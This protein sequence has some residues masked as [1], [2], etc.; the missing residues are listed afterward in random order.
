MATRSI[1][2]GQN[3]TTSEARRPCSA[4]EVACAP[5][6]PASLL[7][8]WPVPN[9]RCAAGAWDRSAATTG[10][11]STVVMFESPCGVGVHAAR[12]GEPPAAMRPASARAPRNSLD[13]RMMRFFPFGSSADRV[14]PVALRPRLASGL[15]LSTSE[16]RWQTNSPRAWT[17]CASPLRSMVPNRS[18][19]EDTINHRIRVR[20]LQ[21]IVIKSVGTDV[22]YRLRRCLA[23]GDARQKQLGQSDRGHGALPRSAPSRA[24]H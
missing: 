14:G 13:L 21:K 24:G 8:L 16:V 17:W 4:A 18:A 15:P 22:F 9:H 12:S 3:T 2:A 1:V 7:A 23:P 6:T 19:D 11:V 10:G 20:L 5:A